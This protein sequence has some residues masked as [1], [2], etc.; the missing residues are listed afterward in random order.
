MIE[1]RG[2][3]TEVR[4]QRTE[5]RGQKTEARSQRTEDRNLKSEVGPGVVPEGRDYAAAR[6]RK[7]EKTK[8]SGPVFALRAWGFAL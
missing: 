3:R 2:Q 1:G 4:R 5:D 7:S 8:D 6:M